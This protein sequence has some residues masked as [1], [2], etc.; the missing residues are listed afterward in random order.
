MAGKEMITDKLLNSCL[1]LT[2]TIFWNDTS[3]SVATRKGKLV[4]F[5]DHYLELNADKPTLIPRLKIIRIEK[6][7][8]TA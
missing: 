4:A 2:I 8:A 3:D 7:V 6:E 5:D 1:N